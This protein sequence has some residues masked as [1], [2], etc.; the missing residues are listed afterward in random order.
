MDTSMGQK[1]QMVAQTQNDYN[2]CFEDNLLRSTIISSLVITTTF[3]IY[4]FRQENFF[5]N[6]ST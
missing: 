5:D 1:D 2:Y 3:T 4:Y 6:F